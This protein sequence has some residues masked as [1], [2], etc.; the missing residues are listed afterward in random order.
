MYVSRR[1]GWATL[2]FL[3]ALGGCAGHR[4][5]LERALSVGH[6]GEAAVRELEAHYVVRCPDVLHVVA[7]SRPELGGERAVGPAGTITL[8]P[9]HEVAVG[10]QTVP[11]VAR[12]LSQRF[13]C[14]VAVHVAHHR[15]QQVF[16]VDPQG[17]TQRALDYRGPESVVDFLRRAGALDGAAL[18]DVRVVR[19]HVADGKPPEVFQVDLVAILLRQDPQ[20]NIRLAPFDRVYIAQT[21]RWR[22]GG[23]LPPWLRP[24]YR[25]LTG[26]GEPAQGLPSGQAG[27]IAPLARPRPPEAHVP[28]SLPDTMPP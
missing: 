5:A 4:P 21:R 10:G 11:H 6:R 24:L 7:P 26:E 20:T 8:T 17:A 19:S 22:F 2:L 14:E 18:D 3:A 27:T 23:C 1:A 16:L 28:G 13:G 25:Q 12:E 9:E 15:S